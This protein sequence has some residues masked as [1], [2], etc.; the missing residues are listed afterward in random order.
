MLS[1]R[2]DDHY[3]WQLIIHLDIKIYFIVYAFI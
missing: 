1:K 3:Y 2:I